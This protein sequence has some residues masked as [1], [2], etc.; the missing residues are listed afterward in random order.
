MGDSRLAPSASQARA[1]SEG[2]GS[3]VGLRTDSE[4]PKALE[5]QTQALRVN[6]A[7]HVCS[8]NP[9]TRLCCWSQNLQI[10]TIHTLLVRLLLHIFL[11]EGSCQPQ[12]CQMPLHL[13]VYDRLLLVLK[14]AVLK[15]P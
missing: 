4:N 9:N 6:A 12:T 15:T 3:E 7:R 2:G 10:R 13:S 1:G 11:L 8:R 5:L 14:R